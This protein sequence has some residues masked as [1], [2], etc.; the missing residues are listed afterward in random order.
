MF[1]HISFCV[2]SGLCPRGWDP[3]LT[4]LYLSKRI[5]Q[6]RVFSRPKP[7]DS[8][9]I[10]TKA[11][12]M[13]GHFPS[14]QKWV[15]ARKLRL[16]LFSDTP[17][18]ISPEYSLKRDVCAPNRLVLCLPK[19]R[20]SLAPEVSPRRLKET[21]SGRSSTWVL[22][23]QFHSYL[24]TLVAPQDSH[25]QCYRCTRAQLSFSRWT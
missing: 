22:S 16:C 14:A 2:I 23:L 25:F 12:D 4:F 8:Q 6:C 3:D 18:G 11:W 7:G 5:S 1:L 21:H 15:L 20:L 17:T 19:F 10:L 24:L 9:K 13:P